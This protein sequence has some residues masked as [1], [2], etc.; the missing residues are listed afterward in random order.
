MITQRPEPTIKEI[1]ES[2]LFG[3][4][5]WMVW[6]VERIEL[7]AK[8]CVLAE[9]ERC[10]RIVD[11]WVDSFDKASSVFPTDIA[12]KT[13]AAVSLIATEIRSGK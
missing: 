2:E 1:I 13:S 12:R 4:G 11:G 5:D 7:I 9:R 3:G 8:R 6:Q 10:A